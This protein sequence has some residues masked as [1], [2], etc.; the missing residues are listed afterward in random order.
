MSLSFWVFFLLS[1]LLA[2]IMH[3]VGLQIP[4]SALGTLYGPSISRPEETQAIG[5]SLIFF[6]FMIW[7]SRVY[8]GDVIRQCFH[9]TRTPAKSAGCPPDIP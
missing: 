3:T 4:D 7:L 8:L 5:A 1:G 2:G 9:P 6:G